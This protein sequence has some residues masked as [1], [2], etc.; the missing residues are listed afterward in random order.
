MRGRPLLIAALLVA[1][2]DT[3][4][5]L[6]VVEPIGAT[7]TTGSVIGVVRGSGTGY[8]WGNGNPGERLRGW[9][10]SAIAAIPDAPGQRQR[11]TGEDNETGSFR[12]DNLPAGRWTLW[13]LGLNP[14]AGMFPGMRL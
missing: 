4:T 3:A 1:A 12:F 9:P 14:L 10:L 7:P 2:C 11:W 13:F 6:P 5:E 8:P